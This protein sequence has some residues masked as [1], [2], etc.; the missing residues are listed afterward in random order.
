MSQLLDIH[1]HQF[2]P[3]QPAIENCYPHR[4]EPLPGHWYSVGIHPWTVEGELTAAERQTFDRRIAH[5]QVLAVGEAGLDKLAQAPLDLQ[6]R[7]FSFQALAAD[8]VRKPLI[9]HL[10][11]AADRLIALKRALNPSQPWII[12]GFRGKKE[13]ALQLL[14]QG[15]YLSFGERYADES[16]QAVPANRLFI[17]TDESPCSIHELAQRAAHV[18]QTTVE[19][20]TGQLLANFQKVFACPDAK[21]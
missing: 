19:R 21:G 20:L 1:T 15:F 14:G 13:Q 7:V 5:P 3:G 8:R 16:L 9:V 2:R 6:E 18:R 11:K 12:H 10:V 4:F 17:E